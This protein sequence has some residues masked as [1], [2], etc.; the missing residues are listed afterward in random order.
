M[1]DEEGK[2][3]QCKA[4]KDKIPALN[5]TIQI[6]N[7]KM[8]QVKRP[9]YSPKKIISMR[10]KLIKL[11]VQLRKCFLQIKTIKKVEMIIHN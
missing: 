1:L 2:L 9:V 6:I 3:I 7:L 4:D 10:Q 8:L 5:F 11:K